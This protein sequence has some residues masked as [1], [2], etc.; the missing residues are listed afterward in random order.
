MNTVLEAISHYTDSLDGEE[1]IRALNRI[2][3]FLHDIS[4]FRHD[5]VDCV[6]W[7][8][9]S[10]LSAN[11]Y[12]PNV[13]AP[14]EKK[15]LKHSVDTDGFTQ[16]VV[17]FQTEK[18]YSI[19]DGFHRSRLCRKRLAHFTSGYVPVTLIRNDRGANMAS[20]I[21]HNRARGKHHITPMSDIV[22]E[23]YHLGWSDER[24]SQELGMDRDEVL[25]LRQISGITEVFSDQDYSKAW[26][27]S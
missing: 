19:V 7:V 10:E 17:V 25:R 24:I 5:P 2:K 15:L 21:R 4:P 14:P 20:T 26:S 11:D 16:P 9:V 8:P 18:G 3:L 12:N 23:L 1:K 6:I 13:M 27:V 22:R